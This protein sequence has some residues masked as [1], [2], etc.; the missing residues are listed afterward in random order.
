MKQTFG[1][2][3]TLVVQGRTPQAKRAHTFTSEQPWMLIQDRSSSGRD[4]KHLLVLLV[5]VLKLKLAMYY[6]YHLAFGLGIF[7]FTKTP[8]GSCA[9]KGVLISLLPML[10]VEFFIPEGNHS[11][12]SQHP[13]D[14]ILQ[15]ACS[16]TP[17]RR[18]DCAGGWQPSNRKGCSYGT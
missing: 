17:T 11:Y 13:A 18:L 5:L 2:H 16:T 1:F 6:H 7:C 15:S 12:R 3:G 9:S 10:H 8:S 4:V 14:S